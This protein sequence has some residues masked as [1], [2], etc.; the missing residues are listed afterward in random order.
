MLGSLWSPPMPS[1]V[2]LLLLPLAV[3]AAERWE[4]TT[5]GSHGLYTQATE[6]FEDGDFAGAERLAQKALRRDPDCGVCRHGLAVAVLQQDRAEEALGLA[7]A[8]RERHPQRP[9]PAVLLADAAFAAGRFDLSVEVAE[10]LLLAEPESWEALRCLIRGLLRTGDLGRARAALQQAETHHSPEVLACERGKLAVEEGDREEA[11]AQLEACRRSDLDAHITALESRVLMMEGRYGEVGAKVQDLDD[12]YLAIAVRALDQMAAGDYEAAAE[13]LREAVAAKPED[14]FCAVL[15]GECAY[16]LGRHQEAMEALEQAFEAEIWIDVAGRGRLVGVL[17]ASAERAFR[18]NVRVGAARLAMLQARD[19]RPEDAWATV[20]RAAQA[21]GPSGELAAAELAL[22]VLEERWE[23]AR[24]FALEA[25]NRWPDSVL[26]W[27]TVGELSTEHAPLRSSELVAVLNRAGAWQ[28][29]YNEAVALHNGGE[30]AACLE[31]LIVAPSF[32]DPAAGP[33]LADLAHHCAVAAGR[34]DEAQAWLATL[35]GPTAADPG[36]L[37]GHAELLRQAGRH[38]EALAL[39]EVSGSDDVP[40]QL[41]LRSMTVEA[42][43]Q[44]GELERAR[45]VLAEGPVHGVVR[46]NLAI[47]LANAQ[48]FAEALV[49]LEGA[50]AELEGE[51]VQRCETLRGEIEGYAEE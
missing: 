50:C 11:R 24:E 13:G 45:E 47:A 4:P 40:L 10:A 21:V 29:L 3:H 26:L 19:G 18:L 6:A 33:K 44:A 35:G 42:L 39:L 2:P 36:A 20:A 51:D 9:E 7:T 25:V 17:T 27:N 28:P 31:R 8:L 43:L 23:E 1:F 49:L 41:A 32:E 12:P 22:L 5:S 15:L 14:A 16:R 30:H 46:V 37:V 38:D 34:L 48:R